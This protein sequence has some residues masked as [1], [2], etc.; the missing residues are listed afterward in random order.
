MIA[1]SSIRALRGA[2]EADNGTSA[3]R[4][5]PSGVNSNTQANTSTGTNSTASVTGN[6]FIAHAGA[7]NTG[8]RVKPTCTTSQDPARYSPAMRMTLRRF[9][10]A[11]NPPVPAKARPIGAGVEPA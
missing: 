1:R 5:R 7:S 8:S 3:S 11:M 4:F 6:A 10:S 9:S 2:T